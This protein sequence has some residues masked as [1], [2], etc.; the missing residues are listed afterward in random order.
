MW[1][2][3]L[4]SVDRVKTA[5]KSFKRIVNE[6][7]NVKLIVEMRSDL[8]R[9]YHDDLEE[10]LDDQSSNLFYHETYLDSTDVSKGAEYMNF[11][12]SPYISC[13]I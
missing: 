9:K 1:N 5:C 3:D 11:I 6:T 8:Y 13:L 2:D 10:E 7:N 4:C 12:K